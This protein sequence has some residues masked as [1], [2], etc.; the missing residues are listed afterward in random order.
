MR[1][2]DMV[3]LDRQLKLSRHTS[4]EQLHAANFGH[5]ILGEDLVVGGLDLNLAVRH[6]RG[7]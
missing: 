5:N 4:V 7:W 1:K 3:K 6:F 2:S